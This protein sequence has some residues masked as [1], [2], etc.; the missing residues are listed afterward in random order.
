[1]KHIL[2]VCKVK[3]RPGA[4][5]REFNIAWV[6]TRI[7]KRIWVFLELSWKV[8]GHIK[9]IPFFFF[10]TSTPSLPSLVFLCF[11]LLSRLS[12]WWEVGIGF[13]AKRGGRD[14]P[15]FYLSS[16]LFLFIVLFFLLLCGCPFPLNDRFKCELNTDANKVF[17][18][19]F[20]ILKLNCL[21]RMTWGQVIACRFICYYYFFYLF[22]LIIW[23]LELLHSSLL[24]SPIFLTS[25]A[26]TWRR[27]ESQFMCILFSC[28][29]PSKRFSYPN[30]LLYT[31]AENN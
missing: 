25:R 23:T 18:V 14:E 13:K 22:F 17:Q 27:W 4:I 9:I 30:S 24:R 10:W 12:I 5:Q 19:E 8:N 6:W 1:M 16:V 28:F 29:S 11:E 21:V 7:L 2:Q 26:T 3:Q 15:F 20:K 31:M